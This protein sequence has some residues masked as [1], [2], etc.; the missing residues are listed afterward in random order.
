MTKCFITG[1]TYPDHT[2][3]QHRSINSARKIM[4]TGMG[5]LDWLNVEHLN[6]AYKLYEAIQHLHQNRAHEFSQTL[7]KIAVMS[8]HFCSHR[9]SHSYERIEEACHTLN[10]AEQREL[11]PINTVR[12]PVFKQAVAEIADYILEDTYQDPILVEDDNGDERYTDEAQ[13]RFNEHHDAV[14]GVL[15]EYFQ[16]DDVCRNGKPIADCDCC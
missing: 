1:K 5:R 8:D 14:E 2:P 3:Q 12:Q 10:K 16:T 6:I 7:I 15:S 9:K 4:E 13:E 11:V